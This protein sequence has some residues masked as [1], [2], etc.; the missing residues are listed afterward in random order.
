MLSL[1]LSNASK[2]DWL[3]FFDAVKQGSR[4]CLAEINHDDLD[5]P[6]YLR[7]GTSDIDNFVQIFFS[8]EYSFLNIEPSSVLDLGGY[9][10]LASIYLAWNYPD[11]SIVLVEPEPDN[12]AIAKLNC[13]GYENIHCVNA[14]VWSESCTITI[15]SKIGGDWGT[16]FKKTTGHDS[17]SSSINAF[18][19]KDLMENH[20]FE[21]IDFLK[22]DIEGS[23][24]VIFS[25]PSCSGWINK[26]KVISCE[27]HDRMIPGCSDAF[28][29]AIQNKGFVH[30]TH[31]EFD[32]Y[33]QP[34][35]IASTIH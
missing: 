3:N 13:R 16:M 34:D 23:E 9:I 8:E 19:V 26:C 35:I 22:I 27:L 5:F 21:T 32:Y 17:L 24:K 20:G 18:S 28:H 15:D 25:D 2:E 14:G 10:G 4:F 33:Y 31:G 7:Q 12:Y 11:A 29:Q 1:N 6:I 30:G